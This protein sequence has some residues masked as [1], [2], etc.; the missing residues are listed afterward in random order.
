MDSVK[1]TDTQRS[2]F[3]IRKSGAKMQVHKQCITMRQV[4]E[5]GLLELPEP[6]E[7]EVTTN[8]EGSLTTPY[9]SGEGL[10]LHDSI[11][12][13]VGIGSETVPRVHGRKF[14][15]DPGV[16]RDKHR[17]KTTR[18]RRFCCVNQKSE[19]PGT[20]CMERVRHLWF[21]MTEPRRRQ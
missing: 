2:R 12:L 10:L 18:S 8:T 1:Y 7:I 9:L 13:L 15:D 5:Q 6:M 14:M 19:A 20:T 3:T 11:N 16:L 4:E 21:R 17:M